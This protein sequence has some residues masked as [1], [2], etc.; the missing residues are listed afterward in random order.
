MSIL[1]TNGRSREHLMSINK[2]KNN[3]PAVEKL[4]KISATSDLFELLRRV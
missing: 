1:D 3:Y 2:A 4:W